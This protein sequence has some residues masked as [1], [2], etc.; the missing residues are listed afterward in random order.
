MHQLLEAHRTHSTHLT[1]R[2]VGTSVRLA[3][4]EKQNIPCSHQ[5]L[6]YGPLG[7]QPVAVSLY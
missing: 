1:G 5:E 4:L 3:A 7:A 2:R 6:K